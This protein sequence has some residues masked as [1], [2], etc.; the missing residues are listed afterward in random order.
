MPRWWDSSPANPLM[1]ISQ[2]A[3]ALRRRRFYFVGRKCSRGHIAPRYVSSRR[4]VECACG[5]TPKRI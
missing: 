3:A 2:Q 1:V 5:P 4:C